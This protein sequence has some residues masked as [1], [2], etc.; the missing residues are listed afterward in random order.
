MTHRFAL[1]DRALREELYRAYIT[2][3][4]A[5]DLDNTPII[6]QVLSLRQEKARLLG[7]D[8]YAQLSM[9]SKVGVSWRCVLGVC[10]G[11]EPVGG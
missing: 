11:R 4:S 2:R 10:G 1:G 8:N 6:E 7:F 3:A 5:G 9:A